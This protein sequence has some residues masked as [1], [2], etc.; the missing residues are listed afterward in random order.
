M[1]LSRRAS[2]STVRSRRSGRSSPMCCSTC[3]AFSKGSKTWS[4]RGAG[5]HVWLD[6]GPEPHLAGA[7]L[8]LV[9]LGVQLLGQPFERAPKLDDI[10]IAIVPVVQQ[11]EILRDLVNG[12]GHALAPEYARY[13][14]AAR[15]G[16]AC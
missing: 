5:R 8:H 12:R 7:A 10:T 1:R 2:R 11:G 4:A 16:T 3:A 6:L 13:K 15:R 9:R 14:G